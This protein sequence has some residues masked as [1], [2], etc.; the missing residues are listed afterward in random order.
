M[1]P[2]HVTRFWRALPLVG[3]MVVLVGLFI[4][5]V[6]AKP[7]L[8]PAIAPAQSDALHAM[9]YYT[10]GQYL[11]TDHLLKSGVGFEPD[12][13]AGIKLETWRDLPTVYM[14]ETMYLSAESAGAGGGERALALLARALAQ[15]YKG[16]EDD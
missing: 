12:T 3:S 7:P 10:G 14:Y 5:L 9:A 15:E 4:H 13:H 6:G 11:L 16:A 2:K 1:G 8:D